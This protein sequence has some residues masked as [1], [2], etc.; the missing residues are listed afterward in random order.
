MVRLL[1]LASCIFDHL[2]TVSHVSIKESL[3]KAIKSL[4]GDLT[5]LRGSGETEGTQKKSA[6]VCL[7]RRPACLKLTG[8]D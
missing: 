4:E 3:E 5:L 1:P 6:A 7:S 2:S 8:A